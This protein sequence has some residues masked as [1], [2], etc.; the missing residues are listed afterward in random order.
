MY[1]TPE[2]LKDLRSAE[3]AIFA[4]VSGVLLMQTKKFIGSRFQLVQPLTGNDCL[5]NSAK[6]IRIFIKVQFF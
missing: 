2:E 5:K 1:C 4:V 3:N 6:L